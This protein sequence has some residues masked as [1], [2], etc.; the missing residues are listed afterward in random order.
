VSAVGGWWW[1]GD[2]LSVVDLVAIGC[3]VAGVLLAAGVVAPK[4][5]QVW[6]TVND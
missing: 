1:I 5:P 2:R 6:T 4:R 3:A